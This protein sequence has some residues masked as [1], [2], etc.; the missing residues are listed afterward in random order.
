MKR[1]S[2][3]RHAALPWRDWFAAA[4]QPRTD[5]ALRAFYAALDDEIAAGDAVCNQSGTC[6]RFNDSFRHYVTGLEIAWFV[7]RMGEPAAASTTGLPVLS[8]GEPCPYQID[9][10]CSA[11][12]VRPMGC[13]I[14]FCQPGTQQWQQSL[15]ERHL[16]ELRAL[17]QREGIEYAYLEWLAGLDAARQH[18]R[19][20]LVT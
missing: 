19:S 20:G 1:A 8:A 12:P 13:R 4:R 9:G 16:A 15:Y 11:H 14:Y 5:E 2:P 7:Q 17:H 10:L 6:C 3:D 18:A